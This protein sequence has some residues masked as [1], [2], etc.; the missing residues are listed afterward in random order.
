[1][2]VTLY[3]DRFLLEW[4]SCYGTADKMQVLDIYQLNLF[5]TSNFIYRNTET[6]IPWIKP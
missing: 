3:K 4:L 6:D 5:G 2:R 1:M